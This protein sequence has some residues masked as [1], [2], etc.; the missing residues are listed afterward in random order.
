MDLVLTII[1][2]LLVFYLFCK[3]IFKRKIPRKEKY[4]DP[5]QAVIDEMKTKNS[6]DS[7]GEY[8]YVTLSVGYRNNDRVKK[9][10]ADQEAQILYGD[11][12]DKIKSFEELAKLNMWWNK[13]P[14]NIR[15]IPYVVKFKTT[16]ANGLRFAFILS[17]KSDKDSLKL[18]FENSPLKE[19]LAVIKAYNKRRKEILKPLVDAAKKILQGTNN[20][21]PDLDYFNQ[22]DEDILDFSES[23][24]YKTSNYIKSLRELYVEQIGLRLATFTQQGKSSA[25]SLNASDQQMGYYEWLTELENYW[26]RLPEWVRHYNKDKRN[27]MEKVFQASLKVTQLKVSQ[28]YTA[29]LKLFAKLGPLTDFHNK[30]PQRVKLFPLYQMEYKMRFAVIYQKAKKEI[31]SEI[32]TAKNRNILIDFRHRCEQDSSFQ[33]FFGVGSNVHAD[34]PT[35]IS[36]FWT[37]YE[38]ITIERKKEVKDAII[39][40]SS[41]TDPNISIFFELLREWE[42][43][44]K[45]PTK[46]ITQNGKKVNVQDDKYIHYNWITRLH[47]NTGRYKTTFKT[48]TDDT[49]ELDKKDDTVYNTYT[50]EVEK[51]LEKEFKKFKELFDKVAGKGSNAGLNNITNIFNDNYFRNYIFKNQGVYSLMYTKLVNEWNKLFTDYAVECFP[52]TDQTVDFLTYKGRWENIRTNKHYDLI[53]FENVNKIE[54]AYTDNPQIKQQVI[55]EIQPMISL[56]ELEAFMITLPTKFQ[57]DSDIQAAYETRVLASLK[58]DM[59]SYDTMVYLLEYWMGLSKI[60]VVLPKV[61]ELFHEVA[62]ELMTKDIVGTKMN[63]ELGTEFDNIVSGTGS[64]AVDIVVAYWLRIRNYDIIKDKQEMYEGLIKDRIKRLFPKECNDKTKV[65]TLTDYWNKCGNLIQIKYKY[66]TWTPFV[67]RLEELYTRDIESFIHPIQYDNIVEYWRALDPMVRGQDFAWDKFLPKFEKLV[68]ARLE[69]LVTTRQLEEQIWKHKDLLKYSSKI[70]ENYGKKMNELRIRETMARNVATLTGRGE[71]PG[72]FPYAYNKDD[73]YLPDSCCKHDP[74]IN[75][76]I[77]EVSC[78]SRVDCKHASCYM[79]TTKFCKKD[80]DCMAFGGEVTGG[81]KCDLTN[82]S[83]LYCPEGRRSPVGSPK[84]QWGAT[85]K[86]YKHPSEKTY[87]KIMP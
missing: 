57:N 77:G 42:S 23:K 54:A 13:Q 72:E 60:F 44:Q 3:K 4:T 11:T 48:G 14:E 46:K 24:D 26:L 70:I 2:G 6:I 58:N 84:C 52:K 67:T 81:V 30:V 9:A 65:S 32:K 53:S 71:C 35:V 27:S 64:W 39:A 1:I 62:F 63:Q 31:L 36:E 49:V 5:I 74:Y 20:K 19:N 76:P 18:L 66:F 55:N 33:G 69:S 73:R 34:A 45:I 80:A 10:Y 17:D 43:L 41:N 83:C 21:E 59:K 40:I 56:V 75:R 22:I 51:H 86:D 15:K 85:K 50:E 61:K 68:S 38:N 28:L 87:P 25:D 47:K 37:K 82:G 79:H 8:F 16:Y 29:T 12:L 78:S 7:L